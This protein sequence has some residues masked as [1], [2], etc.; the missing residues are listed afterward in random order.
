MAS[1]HV[2]RDDGLL[3]LST[4]RT[5]LSTRATVLRDGVPVAE[6]TGFVRVLVPLPVAGDEGIE[7][8]T[9]LVLAPA[10]GVVSRAMLLVPRPDAPED[11]RIAP[12]D[13]V[14]RAAAAELPAALAKVATLSRAERI[15]F[16]P[17]PGTLAARLQRLQR[18][19]PRLWAARHVVLA[20]ARVLAGLLGVLVF[21]QVVLRQ[22]LGWLT[23]HL[24][25][26]D[27][28]DIPWPDID[29]PS[30]PWPDIDLPD[31]SLP[32]WLLVLVGTA[33][34]W[35]PILVAV[36]LAVREVRRRK[37]PPAEPVDPGRDESGEGDP[38]DAHRRP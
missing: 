10:P 33:K 11:D 35:V 37:N 1:M 13:E 34:F 17:A 38:P 5:G 28:P 6:R 19:H 2:L 32:G 15:P 26:V 18:E 4:H 20:T 21:L 22:V 36:V 3:E 23:D 16:E 30:I 24:P 29:L 12:V 7:P 27:L 25:D 9:V 14:A 31:V 8:P